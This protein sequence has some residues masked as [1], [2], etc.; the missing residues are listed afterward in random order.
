[1][2]AEE[3]LDEGLDHEVEQGTGSMLSAA[4]DVVEVRRNGGL[5]A[6][7]GAAGSAVSIAYLGRA[8]QT[9]AVLDW[10]LFGA[11]GILGVLHLHAF[12]D[13]R[14][15]LL[16]ADAQGVRI[17]L[18]RAWRGMPWGALA[19]VEHTPRPGF[20]RDGRLV[21]VP[22]NP[23]RV[24]AELDPSGR[25]Q[26]KLSQALYGTPFALPLGLSTRVS[27]SEE[28]LTT[29][30]RQ[31]AG[32]SA[33]VVEL[34]PGTAEAV[35]P[36][37]EIVEPGDA[38]TRLRLPDPRPLLAHLI[39]VVSTVFTS[40]APEAEDET[41]P[42]VVPPPLVASETPAPLREPRTGTRAE[43][44]ATASVPVEPVEGREL[45][46]PGSIN[47]VE[48]AQTWGDRVRPIAQAGDSVEPLVIDDFE[49]DPA[50]DPVI[51]PELLA[52]RTRIGLTV[53]QL[54]E[55][56]RIR[57][58]V[59]ECIEVDDFAPCG[60]DFYARGHLRTLAR[61]LGVDAAPLLSAY[62]DRY[63]DAPI[64]PRRVFE[65]ELATGASGGIRST[66]GGP[67]WSLL[68]AAVMVVVL[69]WSIA[70]LLMDDPADLQTLTPVG[71]TNDGAGIPNYQ[72]P[73]PAAVPVVLTTGK[74]GT[75]IEVIGKGGEV[76]L[77]KYVGADELHRLSVVPPV[78]IKAQNGAAVSVKVDGNDQGFLGDEGERVDEV[79]RV[80]R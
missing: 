11:M 60:G 24:L 13:A 59:I 73:D 42:V 41:D 77:K 61:I 32:G 6:L 74:D 17:R 62:N 67:N 48:E 63:A 45:R 57:P 80:K 2:S 55:R 18:G 70:R 29:A 79:F 46:R 9:G 22:R 64:N 1:M 30:L 76:V 7:V 78:R 3:I 36:D 16:V 38:P 19:S 43:A 4:P 52:A 15:P 44:R 34:V 47:L 35:E 8:A 26:S 54:A 37:V 40:R 23:E 69:A 72:P 12:V 14:T 39:S 25:R 50:A 53:D 66:R 33:T 51:G 5:G 10:V 27:G 56:T 28:D 58:H 71:A 65:A 20:L 75:H 21:L 31:L 49:V 68:M